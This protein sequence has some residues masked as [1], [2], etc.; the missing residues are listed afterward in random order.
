MNQFLIQVVLIEK[1][2]AAYKPLAAFEVIYG[3][4]Q[5]SI[6]YLNGSPWLRYLYVLA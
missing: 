4:V 2:R 6:A 1:K 3:G 5:V